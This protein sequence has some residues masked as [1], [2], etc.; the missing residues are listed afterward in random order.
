MKRDKAA[1]LLDAVYDRLFAVYGD[2][3]CPLRHETPFQ[4]LVAVILSAQC[5]DERVNAVTPELFRRYPDAAAMSLADPA[6]VGTIIRSLGLWRNK[7]ASLVA[8]SRLLTENFG[9]GV[10][11]NMADLTTLPG[12]GRKSA[13]VILGNAFGIPGFPVDTH[14]QRLLKHLRKDW[15]N[16]T[17]ENLE[18]LVNDRMA[19]AR[20][21][22]FS[23]LLIVHGRQVC[24]AR[25][26]DC[27][28]C[29]LRDLCPDG[30]LQA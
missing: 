2:C 13:N 12:V 18:R 22:N 30:K 10:P 5:R 7:A 17:P 9:G 3:I 6:D 23:H 14:V 15:V 29:V 8:L 21:T 26:P 11:D 20:W 1:A 19:A 25:T 24:H 16:A 27:A 28:H 4:L